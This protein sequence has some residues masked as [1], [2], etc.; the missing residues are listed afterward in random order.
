MSKIKVF[1]VLG[2]RRW[3]RII[4]T[5]LC[6]KIKKNLQI[7]LLAESNNLEI[8]KWLYNSGLSSKIK[9]INSIKALDSKTCGVAFVLNS[10][11]LHQSSIKELL[12]KGYNIVSEKP[13]TFSKIET[14]KL[15]NLALK[16]K[17]K[18]MCTNTYSFASYLKKLK[19]FYVSKNQISDIYISW[20]D[21]KKEFR[22]HYNKSY[23]STVPIIYD[24]LPHI[25]N[26]LNI[27]VGNLK[28]KLINLYVR[29]GGS[30]VSIHYKTKNLNIFTE[31]ERNSDKRM[32]LIKFISLKNQF[33]FDFKK[34]PGL[35]SIN[36][37][38]KFI[39][40]KKFSFRHKPIRQMINSVFNF[41]EKN[42]KDSRLNLKTSLFGNHLIDITVKK[43][44]DNQIEL[45]KEN[46]SIK[47]SK[48]SYS[49]ALKEFKSIKN[50]A[51][52]YLKKNSF[53][54]KIVLNS[55]I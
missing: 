21:P 15:I 44:V 3:A 30:Y 39:L 22:Y 51:R 34:E 35:I 46:R 19:K 17:L 1:L 2:N 10:A 11:Y 38:P 36:K 12:K 33:I 47:F 18:L 31:L 26:I 37:G 23:D 55:K 4:T 20:K 5:E 29:N 9:I 53:L 8:K 42:K 54:Y 27:T 24:I 7:N 45:I 52:K 43:Y 25:A 48:K 28:L 50:R 6:K 16:K 40:D 14:I 13:L 32:R 49:Y 41:V